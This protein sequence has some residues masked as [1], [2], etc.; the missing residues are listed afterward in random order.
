MLE[1][2]ELAVN[3]I[4]NAILGFFGANIFFSFFS[5]QLLQYLWALIN[6]LQILVMTILFDLS[7]PINA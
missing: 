3:V 1:V 6:A 4:E 5:A 7:V 2:A